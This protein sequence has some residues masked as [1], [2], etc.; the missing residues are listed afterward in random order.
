MSNLTLQSDENALRKHSKSFY[1]ASLFLGKQTAKYVRC[2]YSFCRTVD[3]L[4][5]KE[6]DKDMAFLTLQQWKDELQKGIAVAPAMHDI[7]SLA[8]ERQL[9]IIDISLLIDGVMSDLQT[10]RI[11]DEAQLTRYCYLVAGTVGL[12]MCQ[13][14][15]STEPCAKKFAIDLGIAMQLTN[16]LRDVAE[17]TAAGRQYIPQ[18]W[19]PENLD[20]LASSSATHHL[21][22]P[23]L[24]QLFALAERYYQ[25]G[26][27]GLRYLPLRNRFC[28]LLA[29]K[30]Y[31]EIGRKAKLKD[32]NVW[33]KRI[34]V[35]KA[36]K[37]WLI[38]VCAVYCVKDVLGPNNL[39]IH[40]EA[41][42]RSLSPWLGGL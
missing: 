16:I 8:K 40:D 23:A 29:A 39:P 42:H 18:S 24:K 17:D 28:V 31:Q 2:L 6:P 1:L 37:I 21:M 30:L 4:A 33:D 41:L 3:D 7:L 22:K 19:M 15:G 9:N 12:L 10:V 5:D 20:F 25:S 27:A 36:R 35:T 11:L 13:L 32:F 26:Y 14:L 34:I 38:S